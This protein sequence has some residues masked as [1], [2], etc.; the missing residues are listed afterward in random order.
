MIVASVHDNPLAAEVIEASTPEVSIFWTEYAADG[1]PV[2]CKTRID[3]VGGVESARLVTDL[4]TMNVQPT[5]REV[6]RRAAYGGWRVQFAFNRRGLR[7]IG[8]D[9]SSF[10]VI[11][12]STVEPYV[13]ELY[14]ID[15]LQVEGADYLI[16][17]AVERTAHPPEWHGYSAGQDGKAQF[18]SLTVPTW[19]LEQYEEG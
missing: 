18:R 5:I 1:T 13:A 11:A 16:D 7:A 10:A 2:R 19:D 12:A 6:E 14:G 3:L 4:K 15:S 17:K 8:D 9:V